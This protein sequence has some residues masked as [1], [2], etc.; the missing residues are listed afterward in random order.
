MSTGQRTGGRLKHVFH[1]VAIDRFA[2]E[3]LVK[4][5]DFLTDIA[6]PA[7]E[8]HRLLWAGSGAQPKPTSY[9]R[10]EVPIW[11]G[12]L[13]VGDGNAAAIAERFEA[14]DSVCKRAVIDWLDALPRRLVGANQTFRV[15]LTLTAS[16]AEAGSGAALLGILRGLHAM[17]RSGQL[18]AGVHVFAACGVATAESPA[19]PAELRACVGEALFELQRLCRQHQNQNG[20]LHPIYLVGDEPVEDMA[21]DRPAQAATCGLAIAGMTRSCVE[22]S[23]GSD[24]VVDPFHF[25]RDIDGRVVQ[26]NNPWSADRPFSLV[27]GYAVHCASARLAQLLAA[28]LA[29]D[30]FAELGRQEPFADLDEAAAAKLDPDAVNVIGAA[31]EEALTWT[32]RKALG[33]RSAA[34]G[35]RG[36]LPTWVTVELL[37][38]LYGS[39]FDDRAWQRL[40]ECYG[41]DRLEAL[42]LEDW[43]GALEELRL[44]IEAGYVPRREEELLLT[45]RRVLLAFDEGLG[46]GVGHIFARALVTPVGMRPHRLA[47]QFLATVHR[48][49][50]EEQAR[51]EK[52]GL[53][54]APARGDDPV[55]RGPLARRLA[56]L[57]ALISAVPSPAAVFLRLIPVLAVCLVVWLGLPVDLGPFDPAWA[58]LLGGLVSG[59]LVTLLLLERYVFSVRRR[60][61]RACRG[62]LDDY[63]RVL[64]IEDEARRDRTYGALIG[65]MLAI[66]KWL[67]DGAESAPPLPGGAM[68]IWL[69]ERTDGRE[70][71]SGQLRA[72]TVISAFQSYLGAASDRFGAIA[73]QL[74]AAFQPSLNET[75]LPEI[76]PA[77]PQVYD[78]EYDAL[79]ATEQTADPVSARRAGVRRT[80]ESLATWCEG[81]AGLREGDALWRP[82]AGHLQGEEERQTVSAWR[83]AFLVPE[84]EAL[85]A[86]EAA[87][88]AIGTRFLRTATRFV[89]ESGVARSGLA[90]RL[91]GH[92]RREGVQ[93]VQQTRMHGR[94]L[95]LCAPAFYVARG[96]QGFSF[97]IGCDRTDPMIAAGQQANDRGRGSLSATLRVH[98]GLSADDIIYYPNAERPT[99]DLGRAWLH[100]Q[101]GQS[102]ADADAPVDARDAEDA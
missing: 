56:E 2:A 70:E 41:V 48:R 33:R 59:G 31:E 29:R 53:R 89:G 69:A 1:H 4:A 19:E 9:W 51:L 61:L 55:G 11:D 49:L 68:A 83:D 79:L 94:R 47:Q 5:S 60:L 45:T 57:Q 88:D 100:H 75:V 58:R 34:S 65:H 24:Q 46:R 28:R 44:V 50:F 78:A 39:I 92:A 71:D 8:H 13:G 18:S 97:E 27:G 64:D 36:G 87:R 73:T 67:F 25:A 40:I 54:R 15:H 32:W 102:K 74:R 10:P 90:G 38:S 62:W 16:L 84:D 96:E 17:A 14:P 7:H 42:P 76:L 99:N 66:V 23:Q 52:E 86:D 98:P 26:A 72:Q 85:L 101:Q 80:A 93:L 35:E 95:S 37:R 63:R 43:S 82:F 91:D 6:D 20:L 30:T 22:G 21:P 77:E 12:E 3:A 81:G